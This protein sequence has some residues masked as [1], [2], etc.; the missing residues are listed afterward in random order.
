[1]GTEY[2]PT[3]VL[4]RLGA[5]FR[6]ART[7]RHLSLDDASR[8]TRIRTGFLDAIERGD[9]GKYQSAVFATGHIRIY[10][11]FLQVD[12]AP[13][14][15][16]LQPKSEE[17]RS[18]PP[19]ARRP[20][21]RRRSGR[22]LAPAVAVLVV[23]GLSAYLFLQYAAF[24]SG[25]ESL[26]ASSA[27]SPLMLAT[28]IPT[29]TAGAPATIP[30]IEAS[31]TAAPTHVTPAVSTATPTFSPRATEL[32]TA[33]PTQPSGV[34]VEAT[35][36]GRVWVQ[37]E[38]DGRVIFSG[39]LNAGDSRRWSAS[40][41]LMLWTGDAANVQVTFNGKSLGRLGSPGQVL[42]VTWTATS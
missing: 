14:L 40:H 15:A 9:L 34:Q 24:V 41:Q 10:A 39:I 42:K 4:A 29:V 35:M 38:S 20:I 23:I 16:A 21:V 1:M 32:P 12:P 19:S 3:A 2:D 7:S 36:A 27:A 6:Q 37:V 26:P 22:V 30:T 13:Y 5:S 11:R 18:G 8:S 25:S 17:I 31:V 33:V 28:P